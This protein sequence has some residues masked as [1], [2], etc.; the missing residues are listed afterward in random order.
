MDSKFTDIAI[1]VTGVREGSCK[2]KDWLYA[3]KH[4]NVAISRGKQGI[5]VIGNMNYQQMTELEYSETSFLWQ[6]RNV[7]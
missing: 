7:Q 1:I 6:H 3:S 2:T 5:I 4:G